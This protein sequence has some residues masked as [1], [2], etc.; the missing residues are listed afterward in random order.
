VEGLQRR[1]DPQRQVKNLLQ[2]QNSKNWHFRFY[3]DQGKRRTVSLGT[4]DE[5]E[6]IKKARLIQ[7]GEAFRSVHNIQI[8]T[9]INELIEDYL[10]AATARRRKPMRPETAK[11]V[12]YTLRNFVRDRAIASAKDVK[13]EVVETWLNKLHKAG[14]S[15]ETLRSYARDVKTFAKWLSGRGLIGPSVL[16][17][18]DE[19]PKI[20]KPW[21]RKA[22]VANVLKAVRPKIGPRSSSEGKLKAEQAA[23]ELKFILYC[24][25]HAGLRRK[26]IGV[27]RV[28]WFDLKAGLLHVSNDQGFTSKDR[29]NRTI[30]LTNE[31][32]EFLKTYLSGRNPQDFCLKPDSLARGKYRYD[33]ERRVRGH[34]ASLSVKLDLHGM[35]RSFASNLVS[36][37]E[38]IFIV[39]Q[40]LGDGVQVVQKHYAYLAPHSGSINRLV[41]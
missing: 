15:Q 39:A 13:A 8:Q 22:E 35:R 3:D 6:A 4:D 30:P 12:G 41:A 10:A 2:Y 38:S 32:H 1:L 25:F 9:P 36:E 34:F 28:S 27:A 33:F 14:R 20:R 40:W 31:F 19:K 11:A 26:E 7:A 16:E 21:L 24:G 5:A 17:M 18:P 29:D 23:R 37:G